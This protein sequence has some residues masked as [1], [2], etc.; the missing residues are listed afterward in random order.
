MNTDKYNLYRKLLFAHSRDTNLSRAVENLCKDLAEAKSNVSEEEHSSLLGLWEDKTSKLVE[1][2]MWRYRKLGEGSPEPL[3]EG[4][5]YPTSADAAF[6]EFVKCTTMFL[7]TASAYL[8]VTGP[9][10][11]HVYK[12]YNAY[13]TMYKEKW[14]KVEQSM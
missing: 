5:L 13:S 8:G 3:P 1:A 9:T 2:S 11:K 12:L 6:S 7:R 10:Y 4:S 14:E